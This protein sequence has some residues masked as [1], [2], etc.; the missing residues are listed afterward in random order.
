VNRTREHAP[1]APS[2]P[3]FEHLGSAVE[4]RLNALC[5]RFERAW[6]NGER[7][8]IEPVLR[9]EA[10]ATA[11][12]VL[13][14][15]L[16]QLDVYYRYRAAETPQVEDYLPRFPE[17]GT[18]W[19]TQ[20][21]RASLGAA[22]EALRSS[23]E[24]PTRLVPRPGEQAGTEDRPLFGP[25]QIVEELARGGMGI[26]FRAID[27][28]LN[29]EVA[30]KVLAP[31]YADS[32][33]A[34]Q[35]FLREARAAAAFAHDHIVTVHEVNETSEGALY[36][37]M[38]FLAGE[39]LDRRLKR[40][41]AL[42]L[43]E[44]LRLAGEMCAG[45]AA[46]HAHGLVHR[47]IKPSNIWLEERAEPLGACEGARAKLLDFGLARPSGAS[48]LTLPGTVSGTPSHMSPEQARGEELDPRSDLFSFGCVLYQMTTGQ[49]AF[50]G[51]NGDAVMRAIQ[52]DQPPRPT[53]LRLDCPVPLDH[54]IMWLLA[55]DRAARPAS[56]EIVCRTL[57]AITEPAEDGRAPQE[58]G[59]CDLRLA[60]L[61][62]AATAETRSIQLRERRDAL[63]RSVLT[64]ASRTSLQLKRRR[65]RM[66]WAFCG[67]VV[68]A[69]SI[70]SFFL[71]R[72]MGSGQQSGFGQL[73]VLALDCE[74]F[75]N[76]NGKGDRPRG[77]LGKQSFMTVRDD[78]VTVEGRLS[79]PAYAFLIA[80][81]PDGSEQLLFPEKD[82]QQ[83]PLSDRPRYP[84]VSQDVNY[85]LNEGEGL[86]VFAVVAS[87]RPLPAY[88]VW[89]P[90]CQASPWNSVPSLPGVV[91]WH[92]GDR[93][94]ALID[95]NVTGQR[96]K[97][98]ETHGKTHVVRLSQWLRQ[99]PEVEAVGTFGF[100]VASKKRP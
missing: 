94:V 40:V 100:A 85:G 23:A 81:C 55:K 9:Q 8:E 2:L 33:E 56:A 22:V 50:K 67:L 5:E 37:V 74:H 89:R 24:A 36:L 30:L 3:D 41:G 69:L 73:E 95:P 46:A 48:E 6:L 53:S 78:S 15:E 20:A 32:P 57:R 86:Q 82:D 7:P 98:Q 68:V 49:A 16:I 92:N 42:P 39:S 60:R 27:P 80:F 13:L 97:G 35:R 25:Y 51:A 93:V 31:Q 4:I 65:A 77:L 21:L 14:R 28:R 76:V 61:T 62:P 91:W 64:Q 79:R 19:L 87:S 44:V 66:V 88:K 63:Q 58:P 99:T 84:S 38:P 29:R 70:T 12:L 72:E 11:R 96:A 18:V 34:R 17:A 47:D 90:Q 26:V 83:P 52:E 43:R 54:L 45:L 1:G 71:L 10:D 75:E 59:A